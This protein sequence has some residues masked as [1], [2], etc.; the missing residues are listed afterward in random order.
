MRQIEDLY[1]HKY[2]ENF[3]SLFDVSLKSIHDA[4]VCVNRHRIGQ[5][6]YDVYVR[7]IPILNTLY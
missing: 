7:V 4:S 3:F 1:V 6:F 5:H 2:V